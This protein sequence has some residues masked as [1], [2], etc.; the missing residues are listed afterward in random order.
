MEE[1]NNA[2]GKAIG[3]LLIGAAI[4]GAL[5]I[6]FAPDKGSITRKKILSSGEELKDSLKE[7]V[8]EL[9]S[10]L[11]KEGEQIEANAEAF[12]MNGEV[13]S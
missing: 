5:G 12:S 11:Q 3:A 6:L 8:G 10:G 9:V 1:S 13:K 4:G 2:N 7:K